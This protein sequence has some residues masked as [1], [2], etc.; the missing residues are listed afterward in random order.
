MSVIYMRAA[1][2]G[3]LRMDVNFDD[4]TLDKY[5]K[6]EIQQLV[7]YIQFSVSSIDVFLDGELWAV[8]VLEGSCRIADC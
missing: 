6:S 8:E 4:E 5:R 7:F 3:A 2:N 1:E